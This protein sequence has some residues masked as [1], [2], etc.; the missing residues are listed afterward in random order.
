MLSLTRAFLRVLPF[1]FF[2]THLFAQKVSAV[3]DYGLSFASHEAMKDQ[4]TSLNLTPDD[5][6]HFK[7]GFVLSFDLSFHRLTNAY[8]YVVRIIA[9]DSVNIDLMSSPDHAEFHDMGVIVGSKPTDIQY[10]FPDVKLQPR[11]WTAVHITLSSQTNQIIVDWNGQVKKQSYPVSQLKTFRFFFGANDFGKFNTADVPPVSI[12][13]V[14]VSN[15]NKAVAQWELKRHATNEVYDSQDEHLALVKNPTWLIDQHVQW[16]HRKT[17][18]IG[19]Y[20]GVA[21]NGRDGILYASDVNGVYRWHLQQGEVT[22]EKNVAGTPVHTDA[23]QLLYV[24]ANNT[25]L[26]YD[27]T[28]NIVTRYNPA[29]HTWTNR[30]TAYHEPI[31]WHNNKF[32]NTANRSLYVFGGYGFFTYKNVFWK[33]DTLARKWINL[34]TNGTIPPRYLGAS[35]LTAKG[36]KVLL[37]GGYGSQ[38]GKQE[39]SPQSFY[40]LYS[41]D[42]SN[43]TVKKI[44]ELA[45]PHST[46]DLVFSNSLVINETDSCFYV[47]SFPKNKYESY[48]KLRRYALNKPETELL[49]DSIP[50]RFHDEHSFC[51]LFLSRVTNELV[52]V[53]A[54]KEKGQYKVA[55]YTINYPPLPAQ[56]VLQKPVI[57]SAGNYYAVLAFG[58]GA[59]LL[60][61]LF[62]KKIKPKVHTP[63]TPIQAPAH[64]AAHDVD[65]LRS[66]HEEKPVSTINLFGGF[67]VFDKNGHDITGKFTMTLKELFALILLHSVKYEKGISTTELQEYLWP[68]KDEVSARNNRNVNIKKLRTLTE[69][70]GSLTIENNNAYLRLDVPPGVFCDYQAVF[71]ILHA[72]DTVV[73]EHQKIELLLKYVRRGSLLPNLQSG[74]LDNFKSDISNKV[75]DALL[76]Y[77]AKLDAYKDDKVLL[78]IADAIFNYDTI[79]Q[80][81]LVIKCSVLNKKGK[82]SL[83]KTWYDHFAKEYKNLYAE[84]YPK[85]FEE[86]IS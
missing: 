6:F 17:F 65:L 28:T 1:L 60:V 4:R 5:P 18:V 63:A 31:Y 30:D 33:Y 71:K 83:A 24:E 79:N 37:F 80:E 16:V 51:D 10:E 13:N 14:V 43:H 58:M 61:V 66:L 21:F 46:E 40:D 11:L 12:K 57:T 9:N 84:N 26:N 77:S 48:I 32:Y 19:K 25:L 81:A 54:H 62:R 85:S 53:T 59:L 44:W 50:F 7:D 22:F 73:Q 39:L 47:L 23:N 15:N 78:D 27:I 86:V 36:D 38:S 67:Q 3:P 55:V 74:W 52:A 42:L 70:I 35:G 41:F 72:G 29:A 8:G 45:Q 68:D 20:P 82:Y 34:K 75:I 56:D 69:E 2:A 76:A 64:D 49:A